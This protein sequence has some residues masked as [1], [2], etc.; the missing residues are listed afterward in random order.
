MGLFN[1]FKRNKYSWDVKE[2]IEEIVYSNPNIP[3][4]S[5]ENQNLIEILQRFPDLQRVFDDYGPRQN[6]KSNLPVIFA[7]E[8]TEYTDHCFNSD[9][10]PKQ[11]AVFIISIH[12][13]LNE[14][15]GLYTKD[16]AYER[17]DSFWAMSHLLEAIISLSKTDI[18][19]NE[20]FIAVRNRFEKLPFS[21][22]SLSETFEDELFRD[23]FI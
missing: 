21:D 19:C 20:A 4:D 11:A 13:F 6:F 1:F 18:R 16:F 15:R 8:I 14:Q 22:G 3:T 7:G 12:I 10:N 9:Y 23:G 17:P 5:V 2:K